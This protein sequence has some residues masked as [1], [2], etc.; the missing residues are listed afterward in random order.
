M[1]DAAVINA[2]PLILLCRGRKTDLLKSFASRIL[3]PE[4]V[5]LEIRAKGSTDITA[6][7]IDATPWIEV[8]PT[9]RVPGFILEWGLGRGESSV[10]AHAV[11]HP[12]IVA[13]ID[14]L[15]ARRC[16]ATWGVPVRG[17]LGIVLAAKQR[18]LI[19][20]ARSVMEELIASGLYLSPSLLNAALRKVGE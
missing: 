14:D 18:G 15:A 3:V 2:S 4:P 13:I 8:I 10:L 6:R 11:S 7:T 19:P 12:G 5:A 16:A 17:T 1:D 20:S 9:G